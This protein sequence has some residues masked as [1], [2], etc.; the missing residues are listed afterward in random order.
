M[1]ILNVFLNHLI[2]F[3][4]DLI[5]VFPNDLDLK[6]CRE[7]IKTYRKI[8]PKRIFETWDYYVLQKYRNHIEGENYNFFLEKNY[9]DDLID[10]SWDDMTNILNIIE[11]I[12][13]Y[14][15]DLEENNLKKT[16]KYLNNLIK[17]SDLYKKDNK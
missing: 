15:K 9:N 11:R 13:Y 12:R 16:M 8:N 14:L 4:D 5:N 7:F 17:L 6:A 10:A 2:D 1:S 3:F